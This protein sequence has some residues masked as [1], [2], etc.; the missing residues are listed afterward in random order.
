MQ[1]F[2]VIL[3]SIDF[4]LLWLIEKTEYVSEFKICS[5]QLSFARDN[6]HGKII[7]MEEMKK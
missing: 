1:Y 6:P 7:V 5:Y 4:I 3:C 2:A